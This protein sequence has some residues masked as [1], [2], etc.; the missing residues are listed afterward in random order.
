MEERYC[1]C[2]GMPM[3]DTKELYGTEKDGSRSVGYCKYCYEHGAF[4]SDCTMEEMIEFCVPVMVKE[5][6]GMS[7]DKAREMMTQYFPTLKRWM[8]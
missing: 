5:N 6:P 8:K 4:T 7:E 3:G 2:C 1:Q